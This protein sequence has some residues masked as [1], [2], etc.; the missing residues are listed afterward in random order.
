MVW[1]YHNETPIQMSLIAQRTRLSCWLEMNF[2][3]TV[4]RHWTRP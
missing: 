3:L 2:F 1:K 4:I